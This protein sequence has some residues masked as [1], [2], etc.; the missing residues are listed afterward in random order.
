MM[1]STKVHL[2]K[3][4]RIIC[5]YG[6]RMINHLRDHGMFTVL[7]TCVFVQENSITVFIVISFILSTSLLILHLSAF[8]LPGKLTI[9][10][11]ISQNTDYC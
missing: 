3:L 5:A 11:Q 1:S 4:F 10:Q 9:V 8:D 7:K 2:L 6:D